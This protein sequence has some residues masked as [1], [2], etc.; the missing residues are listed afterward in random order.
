MRQISNFFKAIRSLGCLG[1]ILILS[2][3]IIAWS[4][5]SA[6]ILMGPLGNSYAQT[7]KR[8][9]LGDVNYWLTDQEINQTYFVIMD[10]DQ[11]AGYA[12]DYA[13]ASAEID[14]RLRTYE[15]EWLGSSLSE[16]EAA[17]EQ[18]TIEALKSTQ[19]GYRA[20]FAS[21]VTAVNAD[22]QE[23]ADR[24]KADTDAQIAAMH[25]QVDDLLALTETGLT[26]ATQ[27]TTQL[28]RQLILAGVLCLIILPLLAV[29]AFAIASRLTRP[30]LALTTAVTA[31]E[32][33][34]FRADLLADAVERGGEMGRLARAVEQMA[35]AAKER[36]QALEQEA[37]QLQD[38]I[39]ETRRRKRLPTSPRRESAES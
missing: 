14:D 25:Q 4:G 34:Q 9:L 32:G 10:P 13:S 28:T 1:L 15:T 35:Q 12:D 16:A 19:Q 38:Q 5:L 18:Q 39:Y 37:A 36:E 3:G 8:N 2:V 11:K 21:L 22:D 6:L 24:L 31:I 20:T 29:W 27:Q 7:E 23:E 26:R 33:N 17:K 30:V